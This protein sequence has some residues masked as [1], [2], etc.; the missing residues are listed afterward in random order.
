MPPV[1]LERLGHDLDALASNWSFLLSPPLVEKHELQSV[2]V[3]SQNEHVVEVALAEDAH[4]VVAHLGGQRFRLSE[5][6][7]KKSLRVFRK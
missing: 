2:K 3:G 7:S 1:E 4:E 5:H 6:D